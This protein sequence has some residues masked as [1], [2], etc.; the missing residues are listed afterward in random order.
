MSHLSKFAGGRPVRRP[1]ALV[2][3][4][5]GSLLAAFISGTAQAQA[6]IA[7]TDAAPPAVGA[8]AGTPPPGTQDVCGSAAPGQARCL[9]LKR[10]AVKE[11]AHLAAHPM[12]AVPAAA[13][14]GYGPADLTAA[15][16]LDNTRGSGQTVAIVDA[17][18]DP[19]A[20]SDLA[21]YR[22]QYGLAAC[23]TAN[24]CFR[25]VNQ[26]GTAS[27]LPVASSG[28]AMEIALDIEMVSAVCPQ[29]SILLVEASSTYISDLGTA[30]DTA[31]TLG[32]KYVSNSYGGGDS[33]SGAYHFDHPGVAI[34][35]STGDSGYGVSFP[36]SATTVTAVGGTSLS[37]STAARG[38]TETAWSGA[39]SGCSTV[40]AR[41]AMQASVGS[42]CANR[43]VA[44]VSAVADPYTGVAVYTPTGWTVLGGTSASSPIIASAYALAGTP[45]TADY[46]NSY[47]YLHTDELNDVTT[48]SN[49]SCAGTALC[50]ARAGWDGPTGLGTPAGA[51]A[52]SA[53]GLLGPPTK[54]GASVA[55][56]S[57][58]IPGLSSTAS[59][60]PQLPAGDAVASIAWRAARADCTFSA[61]SAAQTQLSCPAAATGSTTISVTVT[62]TARVSKLVSVPLAFNVTGAK[63]AVT[64]SATLSGQS[65]SVQSACTSAASSLRA[66]VVDVATGLPV[67]G[68]LVS[69]SRQSGVGA[70]VSLA[71][72]SSGVDGAA[73]STLVTATPVT[74]A[75]KSGVLGPFLAGTATSFSVSAAKCTPSISAVAS[76][77]SIY[78]GDPVTVS[79]RLTRTA[80]SQQVALAGAAVQL[81]ETVSG[82]VLV[83]ANVVTAADGSF[84]GSV[85][86]TSSGTLNASLPATASWLG[87]TATAGP[88]TVNIAAS[89]L[90]ATSAA[91][92]V[93]YGGPL[94]VSGTLTRDAG[95]VLGPVRSG[96]VTVRNTTAAGAVSVLGAVA[97]ATDGSWKV[98]VGPR[99]SGTLSAVYAGAAGQAPTSVTIGPMNVGTWSLAVTLAAQLTK[100]VA[101][102][103]NTLTGTLTRSYGGVSGPAAML[104]VRLYLQTTTGASVLLGT[105]VSTATG[106]FSLTVAPAENGSLVARIVAA[107]GYADATSRSV[108]VAVSTRLTGTT[109]STTAVRRALVVSSTVRVP[110][111]SKLTLQRLTGSGWRVVAS[112]TTSTA[113]TAR[114][115]YIPLG[116]GLSTLRIVFAG[117]SRGGT[118]T[119]A[120]MKVTI[121]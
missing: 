90:T 91:S 119:S 17:Y 63:R 44:D 105:A 35:A 32:A 92:D 67:K 9:S 41:P 14:S 66:S 6:Q 36:A 98:T 15:Y 30:V 121:R 79:G 72:G 113:G 28:W 11:P 7:I 61:P 18:D 71:S 39:G 88:V 1:T 38:W 99:L 84:A 27:P 68:I 116:I 118:A 75:A 74:I 83:L 108:P 69:F 43:A 95:G 112:A 47:P 10:T 103:P 97:L 51:A 21:V 2:T 80:G 29:C 109:A 45:G 114:L 4:I 64:V 12:A 78:Y 26:T 102:A 65:G 42:G 77:S 101:M 3:L 106:T 110:R 60:T 54:L 55:L 82:R 58:V 73:A 33:N 50:T 94:L 46:P 48:G 56:A 120:S 93:G 85:R 96:T 22:A 20:E 62:D 100:Q 104:P 31:V 87:A 59:V 25:K 70:P 107:P 23:T 8:P 57:T 117:D 24:G 19:T 81:T 111:S 76:T 89:S 49:G 52:F 16:A 86:P 53:T 37:R 40:F 13:P 34:T 115:S 5:L